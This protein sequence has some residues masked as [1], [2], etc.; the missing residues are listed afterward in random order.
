MDQNPILQAVNITKR[1][2]YPVELEIL[3][4]I[5]L[6]LHPGK[7]ISIVG[8][9]GEGKTTFL[10]IL[11]AIDDPTS[12]ELFLGGN[13]VHSKSA[14]TLRNQHIG[15]IFQSFH[16]LSDAT[17]LENV[18]MPLKIARKDTTPKSPSYQRASELLEMVGLKNRLHFP[19]SKLSGGEKQR[20]AIARAFACDPSVIF[21]DEPTGNLDH[22]TAQEIQ[23]LL[24]SCTKKY[25]TA[26]LL[27]THNLQ[28]AKL[29]DECYELENGIL[30]KQR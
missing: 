11:G 30:T 1:F 18:L 23:D 7:S 22:Q 29:T 5:N 26:L 13:L 16:L 17:A 14:D 4:G 27:V 15:F 3:K 6:T 19:A 24:I 12:G 10:H 8:K 25:N 2:H 20:V 21:A 28:L 9:S